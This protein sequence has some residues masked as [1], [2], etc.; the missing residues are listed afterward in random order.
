MIF[1]INN[2]VV[3]EKTFDE[4]LRFSISKIKKVDDSQSYESFESEIEF[5]YEYCKYILGKGTV[6]SLNGSIFKIMDND[7]LH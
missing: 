1:L 4:K 6:K 5:A 7:Y 3:N 2:Q